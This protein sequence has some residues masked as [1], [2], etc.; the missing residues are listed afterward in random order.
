[1]MEL[2]EAAPVQPVPHCATRYRPVIPAASFRFVIMCLIDTQC[3]NYEMG[4]EVKRIAFCRELFIRP[5]R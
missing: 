4:V 1:M 3:H 5:G 2:R